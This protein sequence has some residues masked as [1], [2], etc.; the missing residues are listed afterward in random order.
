MGLFLDGPVPLDATA[1][2]TQGVPIPSNLAFS[3]LF[4]RRDFDSD[5]VDFGTIVHTNRAAQFRNWDGSVWTSARDTGSERRVKM[6]PLSAKLFEGEYE[7][8]QREFQANG[9]TFVQRLVD[10]VYN[11]LDNLTVQAYNRVELAWGDVLADGVLTINENGVQQQIDYM[12]PSNQIVA[13][14][15]LWSDTTNSTPLTD[16]I[17]WSDVYEATNGVT[18]GRIA[19][20]RTVRR[21]VERNKEIIDAVYGSTQGKTR[22]TTAELNQLLESEN[23]PSFGTD[24]NS[25]FQVDTG[26]A[27]TNQR[28]L[29]ENKLL[30]LPENMGELG[31]TAWGTPTTAMELQTRNVQLQTASGIVGVIVREDGIPFRKFTYVDAVALPIIGDP[32]KLMVSTVTA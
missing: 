10:A 20:S 30:L 17:A 5:T 14:G 7:R 15:T 3:Q 18:P 24:Y 22:V 8:R 2:Y 6:L 27:L 16:L 31:F 25:N 12:V 23:L 1:T 4:P 13:P 21:L 26:S 9:S 11:D 28:V 32:R 29:A 19:T